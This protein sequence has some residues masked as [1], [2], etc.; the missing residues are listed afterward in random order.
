MKQNV[1]KYFAIELP[2][3]SYLFLP[4][5]KIIKINNNIIKTINIR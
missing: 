2:A 4:K 1:H 5:N 3:F